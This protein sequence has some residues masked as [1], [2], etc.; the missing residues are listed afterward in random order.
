MI[1]QYRAE[2]PQIPSAYDY[3]SKA[4]SGQISADVSTAQVSSGGY[5]GGGH[6][7][8]NTSIEINQNQILELDGSQI[9]EFN[10]KTAIDDNAV[11]GGW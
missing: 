6:T 10:R 5:S 4:V 7:R 1:A 8:D 2:S 9:A 11:S 3:I